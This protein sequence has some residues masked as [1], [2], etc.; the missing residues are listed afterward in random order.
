M[1]LKIKKLSSGK[2]QVKNTSTGN[3]TAK[4]TS[5]TKAK[6]QVKKLGMM[7]KKGRK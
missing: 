6:K 7:S 5:L 3:I 2:Y 1:P 4:A